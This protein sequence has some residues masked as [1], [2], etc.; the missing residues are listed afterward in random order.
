MNL[1]G[2]IVMMT[3]FCYFWAKTGMIYDND[4]NNLRIQHNNIICIYLNK[5]NSVG[6]TFANYKKLNVL[7][8]EFLFKK[9]VIILVYKKN[10][11]SFFTSRLDK[12]FPTRENRL[13]DIKVL[14]TNKSFG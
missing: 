2:Q 5:Y 9:C 10:S 8:L 6:Y 14:T 4:L 12:I 13:Y 7:P 1:D 3:H 11:S